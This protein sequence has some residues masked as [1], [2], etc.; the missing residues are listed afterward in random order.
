M[1]RRVVRVVKYGVIRDFAETVGKVDHEKL[2][3]HD[4]AQNIGR[5]LVVDPP[6]EII[7]VEKRAPGAVDAR[8]ILDDRSHD[9]E[10]LFVF[11]QRF[12]VPAAVGE[13]LDET[14]FGT[15]DKVVDVRLAVLVL[16]VCRGQRGVDLA[17]R[18]DR[19]FTAG[20]LDRAPLYG[21]RHRGEDRDDDDHQQMSLGP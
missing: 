7:P 6:F 21:Q 8:D 14:L 13:I 18:G 1:N 20:A 15:F 9:P 4:R 17:D 3:Q 12:E 19:P 5:E 10:I 16:L 11:R 2:A